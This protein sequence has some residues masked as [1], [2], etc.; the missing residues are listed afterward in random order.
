[1]HLD[2]TTSTSF[3]ARGDLFGVNIESKAA[4]WLPEAGAGAGARAR[5]GAPAGSHTDGTVAVAGAQGRDARLFVREALE[6]M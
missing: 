3:V 5:G 1:M 4:P 2:Y 6:A